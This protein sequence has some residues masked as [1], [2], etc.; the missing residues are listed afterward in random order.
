MP[1]SK[2][3]LTQLLLNIN[4]NLGDSTNH[5][6]LAA[7]LDQNLTAGQEQIAA[8]FVPLARKPPYVVIVP[9]RTALQRPSNHRRKQVQVHLHL[10]HQQLSRPDNAAE[11]LGTDAVEG[12]DTLQTSILEAL[13][14]SAPYDDGTHVTGGAFSGYVTQTAVRNCLGLDL[15]APT[16]VVVEG[17]PGIYL[18]SELRLQYLVITN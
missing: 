1:I 6:A 17:F 8:T 16:P 9:G 11:L 15:L 2:S 18:K 4:T 10:V 13:E 3:A 5:T 14:R 7:A 12:V